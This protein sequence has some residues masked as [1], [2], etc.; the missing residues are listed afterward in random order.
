MERES[1][2]EPLDPER[3][4]RREAVRQN[5]LVESRKRWR[6]EPKLVEYV[7][8]L[9]IPEEHIVSLYEQHYLPFPARK[10]VLPTGEEVILN[11]GGIY[12]DEEWEDEGVKSLVIMAYEDVERRRIAKQNKPQE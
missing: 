9:G 5:R 2:A 3:M 12:L 11:F 7:E 6:E 4:A 1:G 8:E 10:L